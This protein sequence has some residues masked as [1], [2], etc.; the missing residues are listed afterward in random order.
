[1][2]KLY[3]IGEMLID[4]TADG[5][6]ATDE[7][8]TFTKNAGGAPANVAVCAAKLGAPTAVVTKLGHDA[9]GGYLYDT[10][11][12]E[13]VNTDHVYFTDQANTALAF[14]SVGNDGERD[15]TFYRNPSADLFLCETDV[16]RVKFEADDILHFG[17]VDLVDYPVK[18]AHAA[19]IR[20]AERAGAVISFDPNLR[21][22]LWKSPSELIRIVKEFIPFADIIKVSDDELT[23]I[24]DSEED[25]C[26]AV[27]K[28]FTGNVKLVLVT[29]GAHGSV[30]YTVNGEKY[31]AP[32]V[33]VRPAD[34]TGAGDTFTGTFLYQ[35]L[36]D[37]I[38][39]KQ[40]A[41][42]GKKAEV[43]LE[44]ANRAAA[45]VVTRRG[46]IPAMPTRREVF[47]ESRAE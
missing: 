24:T 41:D 32:A 38:G 31:S 5:P 9:F 13:G 42:I 45:C 10:L 47:G 46:A 8:L 3:A 43:Y 18:K 20:A 26:A 6:G 2:K 11:V 37:G 21:Y 19:A 4:F 15:F 22:P 28:L 7:A 14:V 30:A 25:E 39:K 44:F 16:D 36:R 29:K 12:R 34:T 17:S 40:I 33:Q 23:D 35:L 27:N 1:M